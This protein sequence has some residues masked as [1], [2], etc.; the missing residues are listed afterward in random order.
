LVVISKVVSNSSEVPFGWVVHIVTVILS[1]TRTFNFVARIKGKEESEPGAILVVRGIA[2]CLVLGVVGDHHVL[3]SLAS[4]YS[5]VIDVSHGR[6]RLEVRTIEP[7]VKFLSI[8]DCIFGEHEAHNST[9][10]EGPVA[11]SKTSGSSGLDAG[12]VMDEALVGYNGDTS[13]VA[14][15]SASEEYSQGVEHNSSGQ[16][17]HAEGELVLTFQLTHVF[18]GNTLRVG[19]V[20]TESEGEPG[21]TSEVVS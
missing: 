15:H 19:S 4:I 20:F 8:M 21:V 3:L 5:Q 14:L 2:F 16:P 13:L 9:C 17:I 10:S 1:S 18:P 11:E 6:V 7:P 12:E